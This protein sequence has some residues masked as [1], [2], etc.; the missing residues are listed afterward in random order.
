MQRLALV[1]LT[2]VSM[3]CATANHQ[4]LYYWGEY[5]NLLYDMYVNPGKADPL[6]QIDKLNQVI[7]KSAARGLRTPPGIYAHLGYMYAATGEQGLSIAAFHREMELY[8]ESKHLIQGM[9]NR[10]QSNSN[11]SVTSSGAKSGEENQ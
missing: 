11:P 8:P 7:E 9:L 1:L 3:G 2:I 6:K 10:A 5:Q 4:Q